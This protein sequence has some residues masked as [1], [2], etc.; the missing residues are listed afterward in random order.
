MMETFAEVMD[1]HEA[2]AKALTII[3][4]DILAQLNRTEKRLAR[5]ENLF[6][7]EKRSTHTKRSQ[8]LYR[9]PTR[10][11]GY[12]FKL[13][14]YDDD[15]ALTKTFRKHMSHVQARVVLTMRLL[16]Q[17]KGDLEDVR[18]RLSTPVLVRSNIPVE[19]QLKI[20]G[21]GL[22]NLKQMRYNRNGLGGVNRIRRRK[23]AN[24]TEAS[25]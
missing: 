9:A 12:R 7:R 11:G 22:E 10:L 6:T 15:L 5:L 25:R 17:M 20:T 2:G 14:G 1:V 24:F 8:I 21:M 16:R 3:C 23:G 13:R 19:V 18:Q 4:N